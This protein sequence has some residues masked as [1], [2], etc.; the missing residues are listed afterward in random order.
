MDIRS[1]GQFIG[2]GLAGSQIQYIQYITSEGWSYHKFMIWQR[3][4]VNC[5]MSISFTNTKMYVYQM[6]LSEP[7]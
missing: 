7:T 6:N 4:H 2:L 3:L 5:R 1:K